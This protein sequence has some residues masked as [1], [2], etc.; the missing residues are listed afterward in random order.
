MHNLEYLSFLSWI[1]YF[2]YFPSSQG[3]R[4]SVPRVPPVPGSKRPQGEEVP[5]E[6]K[7]DIVFS[8]RYEHC[9]RNNS[10]G[11]RV[12]ACV[13]EIIIKGLPGKSSRIFFQFSKIFQG[14]LKM[15]FC[16]PYQP[17]GIKM[18]NIVDQFDCSQDEMS[19]FFERSL[20]NYQFIIWRA[21]EI[22]MISLSYLFVFNK[23]VVKW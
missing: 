6:T 13:C 10:Q 19:M 12:V 2:C 21:D 16:K 1:I 18:R 17:S 4:K 9:G 8:E 15:L 22:L 23:M 20:E 14:S 7:N 5:K 11:E 3:G